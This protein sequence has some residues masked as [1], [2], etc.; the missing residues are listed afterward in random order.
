MEYDIE[1][2]I[3]SWEVAQGEISHAR[4]FGNII[5]H[6]SPGGKPV[7]IEILEASNLIGQI[8]KLKNIKDINKIKNIST[9]N[10]DI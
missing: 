5:I 3:L 7:L 4:E 1:S 6:F 10:K 2:N 8:D 9:V